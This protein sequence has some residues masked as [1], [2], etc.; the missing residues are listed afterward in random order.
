MDGWRLG[1]RWGE[2]QSDFGIDVVTR[3]RRHPDFPENPRG[4]GVKIELG[5][6]YEL[7]PPYVCGTTTNFSWH[8][9]E[10]FWNKLD[11]CC[12]RSRFQHG[13]YRWNCC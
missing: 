5:C 11:S 12:N 3:Q 7:R 10:L 9:G 6:F 13:L 4:E 8:G 2:I 1:F